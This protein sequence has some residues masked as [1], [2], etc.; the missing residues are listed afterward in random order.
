MLIIFERFTQANIEGINALRD[1][2]RLLEGIREVNITEA[3]KGP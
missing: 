2:L 1:R 3:I